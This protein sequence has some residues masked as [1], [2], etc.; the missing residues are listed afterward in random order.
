MDMW[1]TDLRPL[2]IGISLFATDIHNVCKPLIPDM[3]KRLVS[4][5]VYPHCCVLDFAGTEGP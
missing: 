2:Q 5:Y 3:H 4:L 1:K